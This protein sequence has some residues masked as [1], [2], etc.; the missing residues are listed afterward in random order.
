MTI[1]SKA[2]RRTWEIEE[3]SN[4]YI[5]HPLSGYFVRVFARWGVSPNTVSALGAALGIFAAYCYYHYQQPL[6]VYFGLLSM[7][8]WHVMDGADGQLARLTGKVSDIG[9]IIDGVCDYSVF[10]SVYVALSLALAGQ[11]GN[12]VWLL[13]VAAGLSHIIQASAFELRRQEYDFWIFGKTSAKF[14]SLKEIRSQWKSDTTWKKKLRFLYYLY[15]KLQY[16]M[17]GMDEDLIEWR[18]HIDTDKSHESLAAQNL[19]RTINLPAV[20]HW[21]WLSANKRT[22]MLFL[23][24]VFGYP[25][26]YFLFEIIILNI[27]FLYLALEQQNHNALIKISLPRYGT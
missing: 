27:L 23:A 16:K 9:M 10:I 1:Q 26:G 25:L 14:L 2:I 20:R 15:V 21:S 7:V 22:F 11:H 5:V 19:Y 17:G 3:F 8:G 12:W 18:T 6:Y 24:C 4:R 13:A